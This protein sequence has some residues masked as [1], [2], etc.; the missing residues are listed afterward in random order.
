[1]KEPSTSRHSAFDVILSMC[2]VGQLPPGTGPGTSGHI[3]T[4]FKWIDCLDSL[5]TSALL[6]LFFF[7]GMS[8]V[9]KVIYA[10]LEEWKE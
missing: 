9:L 8:I 6:I 4:I 1:M 2:S 3:I 7:I 10:L 5:G